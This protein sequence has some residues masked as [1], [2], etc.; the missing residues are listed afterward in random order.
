MAYAIR[1][2]A[3][4]LT[5]PTIKVTEPDYA[6]DPYWQ[7]AKKEVYKSVLELLAQHKNELANGIRYHKLL[8]GTPRKKQLALT[9]DDGPHPQY[10]PQLLDILAKE[11]V[12]ATFFI[13]GEM[14]DKYPELVR[15]EQRAGHTIGNHTY[16]HVNLTKIL[17][18]DVAT[19]I[20]AGGEAIQRITGHAPHF[21]R[22]PGGDYD[23][24]V[25]ETSEA[26]GYTITLWTDDPGDYA[27]PGAQVILQR[28]LQRAENGGI[29]LLHDGIK[30]TIAIL[31]Q[32]I[33][34]LKQRGYQFVTV[35][36]MMK[37]RTAQPQ[38]GP[39]RELPV[40]PAG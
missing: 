18:P 28:T 24:D 17:E 3:Q 8:R 16:H 6:N 1:T 34:T 31:P 4:Q 40:R 35:D 23:T 32:L 37:E 36:E 2:S 33:E 9:F 26:L 22:P 10:T 30:Q 21:F 7:H 13:V 19:E 39:S 12:T 15:A 27:K 38:H 11:K 14:A 5:E 20:K 29:I 25:A